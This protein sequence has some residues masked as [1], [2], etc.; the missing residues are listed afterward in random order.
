MKLA[1]VMLRKSKDHL[2]Y[3]QL[4]FQNQIKIETPISTYLLFCSQNIY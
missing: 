4:E 2:T 3:D 1:L